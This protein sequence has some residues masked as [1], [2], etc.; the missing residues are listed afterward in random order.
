[1]Y[2]LDQI[3]KKRA[4][5]L[6]FLSLV[7]TSYGMFF[8][9][10]TYIRAVYTGKTPSFVSLIASWLICG[11]SWAILTIPVFTFLRR[12]SLERLG[13]SRFLLIHIPAGTLFAGLALVLY[14]L[15]SNVLWARTELTLFGYYKYVFVREIQSE[16]LIYFTIVSVVTAFK[17]RRRVS[18][19]VAEDK[20]LSLPEA[21]EID[22]RVNGD[23]S[24]HIARIPIKENGR[25]VIVETRKIERL[26]SY[27]NYLFV[28]ALG[29]RHMVRETMTAMEAKLDPALFVRIRRSTILRIDQIRELRRVSAGEY[30]LVLA[31]GSITKSTRRYRQKLD[32]LLKD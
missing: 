30:K 12:F 3:L 4:V 29:N 11:Y 14:V 25:I 26:E 27:G 8:A 20:D 19:R 6:L 18:L 13:W 31:D 23:A 1:M 21:V 15:I 24:S 32:P 28:Y 22:R 16:F 7:W 5:N 10:Q 9:T 17:R 2:Q